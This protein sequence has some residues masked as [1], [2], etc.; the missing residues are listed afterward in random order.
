M[1]RSQEEAYLNK[2]GRGKS[3]RAR[4]ESW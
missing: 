1:E 4:I 2:A 3:G